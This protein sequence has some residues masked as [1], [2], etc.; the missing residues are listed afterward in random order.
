VGP[1]IEIGLDSCARVTL[2]HRPIE[3]RLD[4]LGAPPAAGGRPVPLPRPVT[5]AVVAAAGLRYTLRMNA[6]HLLCIPLVFSVFAAC[7]GGEATSSS[8]GGADGGTE[9]K[10]CPNGNECV[11]QEVCVFADGAC[12]AVD[13]TKKC[14]YYPPSCGEALP[15]TA[16]GCDGKAYQATCIV[17]DVDLR[18]GACPP[19]AGNFWCGNIT[20]ALGQEHCDLGVAPACKPLPAACVGAAADCSCFALPAGPCTCTKKADGHFELSCPTI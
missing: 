1:D 6:R 17:G 5:I 14:V 3:R 18:P 4:D 16:C 11:G 10:A 2:V 9:G 8:T 12:G 15:S 19:P 7:G 20:C 13:K